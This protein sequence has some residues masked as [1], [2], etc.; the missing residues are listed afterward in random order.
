MPSLTLC[1]EL[2]GHLPNDAQLLWPRDGLPFSV[3]P[4]DYR[5][6]S[7]KEAHEQK[8]QHKKRLTTARPALRGKT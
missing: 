2:L 1:N 8:E 6:Q 7:R 3:D 5:Q 4:N